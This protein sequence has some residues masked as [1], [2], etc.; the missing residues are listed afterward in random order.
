MIIPMNKY[1]FVMH[2]SASEPFLK[3]VQEL[4]LVD[5]VR[6]QKAI[7]DRSKEMHD[8]LVRYKSASKFL[9][10]QKPI[11]ET[12]EAFVPD[13]D[14][15]AL[16]TEIEDAIIQ[17]EQIETR[18]LALRKEMDAAALWGAFN[19][20]DRAKIQAL[21]YTL[22][23]Y[24]VSE[25]RYQPSWEE[26][27]PLFEM[28]R[29]NGMIYFMVL[30]E[31]GTSFTFPLTEV[32][33]PDSDIRELQQEMETLESKTEQMGPYFVSLRF[34]I[35]LFKT[36][37]DWLQSELDRYLAGKSVQKEAEDTI[38]ILT[39]F[40]PQS[41]SPE[42]RRFLDDESV[43][44]LEQEATEEDA[45]PIKLKN[46]WF[47]R[48]YEAIGALYMLP[49]YGEL[50]L[51][52]FFAPFYM[53]F[54]GI[55]LGDMGYG[56]VLLLGGFAVKRVMPD[57][58][59]YATLVQMLGIGAI[60]MGALTGGFFGIPISE[61][62]LVPETIRAFLSGI[63][64]FWFAI[65]FGIF[66]IIFARV[67]AAIDA[68][69]RKGWQHGMAPLGWASFILWLTYVGAR[70]QADIFS[71]PQTA[72][73]IWMGISL[74]FILLFTKTSGNIFKRV[75]SGMVSLY[76]VTGVFGDILSYIRLFGLGLSGGILG[77][78]VNSV[79]SNMMDIAY[80]GWLFALIMLLIGHTAVLLL[81]CL[82]A[83]V[84]PMRLTFVE[85]YKNVG[86][87]G[88]GREFKPLK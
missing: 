53:L 21:G 30:Q 86:F 44:Y 80:I 10:A 65:L 12:K 26:N 39:G 11:S 25:K 76:D 59:G 43:I 45:P 22:H 57:F 33:F 64:T 16:L 24:S 69:I 42:I 58:R 35:E 23:A 61:S 13:K 14:P 78:I 51:T 60:L 87:T 71:I 2:H 4:G 66:Q 75:L 28:N 54:F 77:L 50:D 55:C 67:L 49:R 74:A 29:A 27:Y 36:Q 18:K 17:K 41:N 48:Q 84:H 15:L 3:K 85:F 56:L 1:I 46:N 32:K 38:N 62:S 52:P 8:L 31:T 63:D 73:W 9:S 88:G 68:M 40:A 83:F 82:G 20:A 70:W 6:G 72:N 19:Q 81:S 47:S 37:I 79:A 5:I 7:D 34:G